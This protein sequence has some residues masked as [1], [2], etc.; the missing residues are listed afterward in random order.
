MSR[1]WRVNREWGGWE[2]G[3]LECQAR[4]SRL[5]ATGVRGMGTDPRIGSWF[6]P[7]P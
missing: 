4:E 3:D 5:E 2:G 6:F 1:M 7:V